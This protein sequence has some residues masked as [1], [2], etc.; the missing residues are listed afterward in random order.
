MLC[1]YLY[2]PNLH[3]TNTGCRNRLWSSSYCN[4]IRFLSFI[5]LESRC[6]LQNCFSMRTHRQLSWRRVWKVS[7]AWRWRQYNHPKR[8]LPSNCTAFQT[9]RPFSS[10]SLGY[11]TNN[12]R[13]IHATL[14]PYKNIWEDYFVI[15]LCFV[16]L[17]GKLIIT[18]L[19]SNSCSQFL[20]VTYIRMRRGSAVGI[21]TD[22]GLDDRGIGVLVPAESQ[23][24]T[25]PYFSDQFWVRGLEPTSYRGAL[26]STLLHAILYVFYAV[27]WMYWY[28]LQIKWDLK[29]YIW[30]TL[31]ILQRHYVINSRNVANNV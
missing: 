26:L 2:H 23:M 16:R 6:S 9:T 8:R 7:V 21:A 14:S 3:V 18:D 13:Q 22:Y 5:F 4:Y 24:L 27:C 15:L 20:L 10:A 11:S 1:S 25:S 30:Y 19:M 12:E 29:M 17:I 28:R 31:R